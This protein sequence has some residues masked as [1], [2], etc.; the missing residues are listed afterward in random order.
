M[1]PRRNRAQPQDMD[2]EDEA[3]LDNL[4]DEA[5]RQSGSRYTHSAFSQSWSFQCFILL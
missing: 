3:A 4:L 1:I 2:S 5:R